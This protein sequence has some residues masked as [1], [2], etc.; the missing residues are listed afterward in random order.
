MTL[1]DKIPKEVPSML[2]TPDCLHEDN[3]ATQSRFP[4]C[5]AMVTVKDAYKLTTDFR[6]AQKF[7]TYDSLFPVL[8][9]SGSTVEDTRLLA[10]SLLSGSLRFQLS[11]IHGLDPDTGNW[12]L[13]NALFSV[14]T[15]QSVSKC[16]KLVRAAN[17]EGDAAF[18][19]DRVAAEIVDLLKDNKVLLA[20]LKKSGAKNPEQ[21]IEDVNDN[22]QPM[23]LDGVQN[24]H[25]FLS[26]MVGN[27][28]YTNH[29]RGG[30]VK[31]NRVMTKLS[32]GFLN[33]E[34]RET[35]VY[36]PDEEMDIQAE[37]VASTIPD[38]DAHHSGNTILMSSFVVLNPQDLLE[39]DVGLEKFKVNL[40]EVFNSAKENSNKMT[41]ISDALCSKTVF[42]EAHAPFL[43]VEIFP[44]PSTST[45]KRFFYFSVNVRGKFLDFL[46]VSNNNGSPTKQMEDGTHVLLPDVMCFYMIG[47]L[48]KKG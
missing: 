13:F 5:T 39:E 37:S 41:L 3:A 32:Q 26:L 28:T 17:G 38:L 22:T 35:P 15:I 25:R 31:N 40:V 18:D 10:R 33:N 48:R 14:P 16:M 23:L 19:R 24:L 42:D 1:F 45:T 46:V 4:F 11:V 8:P 9:L 34:P 12:E 30:R 36:D 2:L 43:Y 6:G 27:D 44:F 47:V 21:S 7:D 29:D 20:I